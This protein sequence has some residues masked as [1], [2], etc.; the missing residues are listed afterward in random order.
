[1]DNKKR[2]A[3]AAFLLVASIS[4]YVIT[5]N[6]NVR[7]VQFASIFAIGALTAVLIR[8]LLGIFRKQ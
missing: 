5:D 4:N 1:M 2:I 7:A 6:D 8:E 3:I